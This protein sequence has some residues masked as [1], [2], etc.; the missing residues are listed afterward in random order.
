MRPW[1]G[2]YQ[3]AVVR[4]LTLDPVDGNEKFADAAG[5]KAGAI[6][7]QYRKKM[8]FR[9]C[10]GGGVK[11]LILKTVLWMSV[12]NRPR[13]EPSFFITRVRPGN[14]K[15]TRLTFRCRGWRGR[16]RERVMLLQLIHL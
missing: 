15:D 8:R 16:G 9:Q 2:I 4:P 10:G 14:M 3:D 5:S 12:T 7:D 1:G 11:T 13:H 6:A